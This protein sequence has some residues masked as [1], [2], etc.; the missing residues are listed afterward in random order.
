MAEVGR[1]IGMHHERPDGKGYPEMLEK[2]EI[3]LEARILAIA[4]TY[5][6][7]TSHRPY[8]GAL[9]PDDALEVLLGAA[10]GQLDRDLVQVFCSLESVVA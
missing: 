5:V 9:A 8:R 4:D 1:W 2:D 3:P 7:L 6:A 10:G